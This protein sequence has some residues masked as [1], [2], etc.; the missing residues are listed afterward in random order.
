MS[1]YVSGFSWMKK[2]FQEGST[3][4]KGKNDLFHLYL[5]TEIIESLECKK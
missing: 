3:F 4:S 2:N 5:T 1:K